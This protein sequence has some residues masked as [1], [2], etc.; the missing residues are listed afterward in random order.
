MWK[1]G[2]RERSRKGR[3]REE[4]NEGAEGCKG[5]RLRASGPAPPAGPGRKGGPLRLLGTAT[6]GLCV[7]KR[8]GALRKR[9]GTARSTSRIVLVLR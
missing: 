4:S 6:G 1:G 8:K 2:K 7:N 9:G 5:G 3:V